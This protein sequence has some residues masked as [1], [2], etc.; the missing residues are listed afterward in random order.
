MS[1][2][3]KS[4]TKNLVL[5]DERLNGASK[6]FGVYFFLKPTQVVFFCSLHINYS[7]V[8]LLPE[9]RRFAFFPLSQRGR[10]AFSFFPLS[11]RG[12][13]SFRPPEG[14]FCILNGTRPKCYTAT[15]PTKTAVRTPP[16]G[17]SRCTAA[18]TR[19]G[20]RDSWT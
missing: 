12:S 7:F 9:R 13:L 15:K 20:V 16:N 19:S 18:S 17:A 10:F 1:L 14:A 4:L 3:E 11:Q 6:Y 5:E 8:F 2:W